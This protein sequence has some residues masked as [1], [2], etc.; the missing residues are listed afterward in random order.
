VP[1][2]A[3]ARVGENQAEMSKWVAM[4]RGINLGSRNRV[5]MATL[6]QLVEEGGVGKNAQ[7][8]LQSGNVIFE[9]EE[10][11]EEKVID[12]LEAR[13]RERLELEIVV[14]ARSGEEI[15]KV[16]RTYPFGRRDPGSL[17]VTFLSAEPDS[18]RVQSVPASEFEPD[19]FKI[20]GREVYL[21][22]PHGYG[23]SKLSNAS[24]EKRLGVSATTRNWR[25]VG[26]LAEMA[27]G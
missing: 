11:S 1:P 25:T 6:R 10:W 3:T 12:S 7:I 2:D 16:A 20:I 14:L 8:Y 27:T 17:H 13:I 9:S 21:H 19:E 15:T 24:F 5:S 22:L 26:A 18:E 4:L 23:R